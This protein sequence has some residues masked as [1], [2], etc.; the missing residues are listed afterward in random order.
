MV[1][2][3]STKL[4]TSAH[5]SAS[6]AATLSSATVYQVQRQATP[7]DRNLIGLLCSQMGDIH[8]TVEEVLAAPRLQ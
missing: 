5:V 6:A 7:V 1:L 8:T 3:D 2:T 4:T